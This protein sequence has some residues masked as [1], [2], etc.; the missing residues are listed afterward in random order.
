MEEITENAKDVKQAWG[1]GQR[2]ILLKRLTNRLI[3][4]NILIEVIEAGKRDSGIKRGDCRA[5]E[6]QRDP[7]QEKDQK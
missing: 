7:T 2:E 6:L 5:G 4:G 3:T 1:R